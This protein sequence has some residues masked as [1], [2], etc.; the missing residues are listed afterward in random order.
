MALTIGSSVIVGLAALAARIACTGTGRRAV[1]QAGL[2]GL[3]GLLI[4]EMTGLA[5]GVT[6]YLSSP[7]TPVGWAESSRPTIIPTHKH[8][9]GSAAV[10]LEDSA[11]PTEDTADLPVPDEQPV[12]SDDPAAAW[13]P[14]VVW[15]VGTAV[16][17]GRACVA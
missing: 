12:E 3:T 14:G 9:P 6:G 5:S 2:L 8:E 15:L 4:A 13:W 10:G 17:A 7:Q 1:W 11:H 16:L